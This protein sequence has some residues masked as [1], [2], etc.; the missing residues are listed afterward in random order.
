MSQG[1]STR[2]V[3]TPQGTTGQY[4]RQAVANVV[5]LSVF[6]LNMQGKGDDTDD[7]NGFYGKKKSGRGK[8][9]KRGG[10][11]MRDKGADSEKIAGGGADQADQ[12]GGRSTAAKW[13]TM[14]TGTPLI[15]PGGSTR[16]ASWPGG[17]SKLGATHATT[18]AT[19]SGNVAQ[20]P[21]PLGAPLRRTSP[22]GG[23]KKKKK[24]KTKRDRGRWIE[25]LGK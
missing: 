24:K 22:V 5:P 11:A 21:V 8:K 18:G 25:R 3:G 19:S 12:A 14:S 16:H 20:Y 1:L 23:A 15:A 13:A 2:A 10:K 6:F 17:A 9:K 7:E 4:S